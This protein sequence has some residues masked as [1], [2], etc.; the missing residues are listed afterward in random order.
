MKKL[1]E[2]FRKIGWKR[3]WVMI[4]GNIFL[5]M[6]ISIFKFAGLGNDPYSGMVMGLSDLFGIAYANLLVIINA[7]VFILQIC[8]GRELIGIGTVVNA[9]LMGYIMT[10]FY[11]IWE[12][13]FALPNTWYI[14]VPVMLVGTIVTGFGVSMYQTPNVGASPYD[15]LSLIM[16]KRMPKISYFWHRMFTDAFCAVICFLVGGIVGLG[17]FVS[18]LG[19]G[20]VIGFVNVRFTRRL[21]HDNPDIL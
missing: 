11:S 4:C 17:T 18:A 1:A 15:C 16:S 20:P 5:G 12:R 10:F 3:F 7:I 14:Q 2:Y 6:G 8:F 19:L 13:F 21:L 9:F